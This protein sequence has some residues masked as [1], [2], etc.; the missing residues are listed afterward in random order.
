M[1]RADGFHMI[2]WKLVKDWECKFCG[3]CCINHKIPLLF[4]EYAKIEP[5]YGP[6]SVEP[7]ERMF[8]VKL[9]RDGKCYFLK[10]Q[11][12]KYFCRIHNE[13]PYVCRMFPFRVL[14]KPKYG[15]EELSEFKYRTEVFYV[16]LNRECNGVKL[17][18]SSIRFIERVMPE[19][20]KI[21][22]NKEGNEKLLLEITS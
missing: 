2:P 9:L 4:E 22:V 12:E 18:N 21:Y 19:F 15:N 3:N 6:R 5:K 17:G 8:Y 20:V 14:R 13:K 10:K 7:G 11:G 1:L 16:Y